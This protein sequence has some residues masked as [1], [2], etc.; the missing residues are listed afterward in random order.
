MRASRCALPQ[1]ARWLLV[2]ALGLSAC[3][4]L[5]T[6]IVS[7]IVLDTPQELEESGPHERLRAQL[8]RW[9]ASTRR[10]RWRAGQSEGGHLL[11]LLLG[12]VEASLS[13]G[14]GQRAVAMSL[15]PTGSG[16]T[17]SAYRAVTAGPDVEAML[18]EA[19]PQLGAQLQQERQL[20]VDG[21]AA[22]IGALADPVSQVRRFAIGRLCERRLV[23]AV[24]AL[25]ALL[26]SETDEPTLMKAVGALVVL[27]DRR[28]VGPLIDLS[29][30]A[31]DT[32]VIQLAFAVSALGGPLAASYLVTLA[33]GH[34][35]P[36]VQR[37]AADALEE[38][39]RQQKHRRRAPLP[40]PNPPLIR[41]PNP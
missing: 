2:A 37:G 29:L 36:L 12:P 9:V 39:Q 35:E 31:E 33:G 21:E 6:L 11:R 5:P 26:A 34:P 4:S 8:R 7:R 13:A 22:L 17:Y 3:S 27:G 38:L 25:S 40:P 24:P 10:L 41:P 32:R 1:L 15:E 14:A 20:E 18:A 30:H 23:G 28:A 16:A 19:L